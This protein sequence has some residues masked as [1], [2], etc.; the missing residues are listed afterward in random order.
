MEVT[1]MIGLLVAL[2]LC[3]VPIVF[4]IGGSVFLFILYSGFPPLSIIAQQVVLGV[5]SFTLMALPL[6]VL[7]GLLLEQG[8]CMDGLMRLIILLLGRFQGGTAI[9]NILASTAFGTLSGSA[10]A[11]TAAVGTIMM[12]RLVKQGYPP[13][14][15]AALDGCS[16]ILGA[17]IPPS[18]AMVTYGAIAGVSIRKMFAGGFIPGF[19]GAFF[20]IIAVLIISR[21]QGYVL[22]K[23]TEK[24]GGRVFLTALKD[25]IPAFMAPVIILGGIFSGVF[26]PTEAASI[27]IVYALIIGIFVFKRLTVP[28][29]WECLSR[30]LRTSAAIMFIIAFAAAFSWIIAVNKVPEHLLLWFTA[31]TDNPLIIMILINILLL[32]LGMFME[33]ISLIIM[34]TPIL[35]PLV[36]RIGYDPIHFGV[37]FVFNLSVGGITPPLGVCLFTSCRILRVD[38]GDTFPELIY[39]L[40]GYLFAIAAIML[41]PQSVLWLAML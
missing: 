28:I 10:V 38:V 14:F 33:T 31:L 9:A 22:E 3:G 32:I 7:G 29:L 39:L 5:D 30:A 16:G 34:L 2:I 18:I 20:L 40:T 12:P 6:F 23:G 19:I 24:F 13:G 17:I 1:L 36:V 26:T 4:A 27:A 21:V 8:G 37:L 41:F 11:T 35:V 25:S 15:T